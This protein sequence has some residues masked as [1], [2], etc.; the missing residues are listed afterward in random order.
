M[1]IVCDNTDIAGHCHRLISG[2]D[3]VEAEAEADTED[4]EDASPRRKKLK[5]RKR[6][7]NGLAGFPELW[8]SKGATADESCTTLPNWRA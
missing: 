2:E 7:G 3:W 5:P 8:N 4:D 6:Y 1:I